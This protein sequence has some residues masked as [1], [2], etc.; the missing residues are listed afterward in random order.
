MAWRIANAVVR[1]EIDN[2]E[3]NRVTGKLWFAGIDEPYLLDLQGNCSA[4]LAGCLLQFSNPHA[5]IENIDQ[6]A[7]L[8]NGICGE[9][10]A[11]RKVKVPTVPLEELSLHNSNDA[12]PF[13][14]G[15]LLYL[16]W[17]SQFNG[18][19]VIEAVDY[20][21]QL[22]LPSWKLTADEEAAQNQLN[23]S[24][25]DAYLADFEQ[26]LNE[27]DEQTPQQ[28]NPETASEQQDSSQAADEEA[29]IERMLRINDLKFEAEK[30]AGGSLM[31]HHSDEVP[32][33]VEEQFWKHVLD[34]GKAPTITRRELLKMD[35]FEPKP[36]AEIAEENISVYLW[37]LID[38]LAAR[39]QFLE[40]T[41]HLSDRELYALLVDKVLQEETQSLPRNTAWC[42]HIIVSEYGSL[43]GKVSGDEIFLRY[44]ADDNW[45]QEWAASYPEKDLPDR[46]EPPFPRD[47]RLPVREKSSDDLPDDGSSDASA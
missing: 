3:K 32:P 17:Y 12:A 23:E 26:M 25:L 18:R 14:W 37:E 21:Y 2:R 36:L 10:T 1:G 15:N 44:Y 29:M 30:L 16:E 41:D 39:S 45:R 9:M 27:S 28:P 42:F 7:Q 6:F 20:Q 11:S 40:Q 43:D 46:E 33:E 34:I 24:A 47:H 8:Q 38:A 4:D 22:S 5:T 35:D 31:Y 19:V 13:K